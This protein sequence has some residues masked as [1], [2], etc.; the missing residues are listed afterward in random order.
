M[1]VVYYRPPEVMHWFE[2]SAQAFEL[3]KKA[4]QRA[5][6]RQVDEEASI[7]GSLKAAASAAIDFGRSTL[8]DITYR[9]SEEISYVLHEDAFETVTITGSKKIPYSSIQ[10]L[11]A[12]KGDKL[13]VQHE[14]GVTMIRPLAYLV[15]GALR[16]PIGWMRNGVEV[17]Y[18][19][20]AQELS[21][22]CGQEIEL[23]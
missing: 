15:S 13:R 2:S 1:S 22:R 8:G 12:E 6:T 21:A 4:K 11:T 5:K 10:S 17:P 14:K 19:M 3:K 18:A 23:P 9:K 16:A 20:L 7:A